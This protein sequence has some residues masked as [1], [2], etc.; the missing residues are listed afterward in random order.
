MHLADLAAR[1]LLT[2]LLPANQPR[3]LWPQQACQSSPP[4]DIPQQ[5]SSQ[6]KELGADSIKN[7]A[8]IAPVQATP[9]PLG[10][11]PST[12]AD[13]LILTPTLTLILAPTLTLTITLALALD[14]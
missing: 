12:R 9:Q 1:R 4:R 14:L 11:R 3:R 8:Q 6:L 7:D 13:T 2:K 5:P 10:P